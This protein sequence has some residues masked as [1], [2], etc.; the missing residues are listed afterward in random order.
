MIR[1]YT[2]VIW[3]A[4]EYAAPV[5]HTGLNAELVDSLESV[6][7]RAFRIIFGGNSFTNSIYLSFCE[8]LAISS[9]Q[10]TRETPSANF[11][12]KIWNRLAVLTTSSQTKDRIVN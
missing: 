1:F 4:I 8:S 5:W 11:F 10:S 6:Q 3:L 7:K 9:L 2:A 12:H